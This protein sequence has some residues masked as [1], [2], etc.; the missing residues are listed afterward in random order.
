[1][2]SFASVVRNNEAELHVYDA[3]LPAGQTG[4]F[5][6]DPARSYRVNLQEL[7]NRSSHEKAMERPISL[8]NFS[9]RQLPLHAPCAVGD[10]HDARASLKPTAE[11]LKLA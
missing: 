11:S 7:Q 5:E 1:M 4:V 3:A 2:R 10:R 9:C 6:V 8:L